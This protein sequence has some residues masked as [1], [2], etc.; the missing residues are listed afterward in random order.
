MCLFHVQAKNVEIQLKIPT[1]QKFLFFRH[2]KH[3]TSFVFIM[4]MNLSH[5]SCELAVCHDHE[6]YYLNVFSSLV[7]FNSWYIIF[8]A[9]HIWSAWTESWLP[10]SAC[11]VNIKPKYFFS[12]LMHVNSQMHTGLYQKHT[13]CWERNDMFIL[14]WQQCN[15]HIIICTLYSIISHLYNSSLSREKAKNRG[16]DGKG[17]LFCES[18]LYCRLRQTVTHNV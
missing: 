2:W 9:A 16:T 12:V 18:R 7:R 17:R 8:W 4:S 15:I 11:C 1:I 6:V 10:H 14:K 3:R 13:K 5:V